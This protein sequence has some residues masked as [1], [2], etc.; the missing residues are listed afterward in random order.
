MQ[1]R[2]PI[3]P[4]SSVQSI[5]PFPLLTPPFAD[6]TLF[7]TGFPADS[8]PVV[9]QTGYQNDIRM[10][11]L[12]IEALLG[13]NIYVP[14]TDRLKDGKTPFQYPV[15]NYIGGIDGQSQAYVMAL[16]P[17]LVGTLEGTTIFVATFAPN[18]DAYA[19]I[20]SNPNEFTAEVKQ[21][22]VPN[23]VSGPGVIPEAFDFDFVT[24]RT[25]KYTPHT[26]HALVNQPQI[27]NNGLC[28]RNL[29]YFNETF[30][31]PAMRT[32][33]VTLYG[34][35][36]GSVPQQLAGRYVKQE[37]YSAS[38]ETVG[39]NAE[40]CASAAAKTDPKALQ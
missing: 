24:A 17:S 4:K 18:N 5:V 3:F 16:I 32:G 19:P 23:P 1:V 7:P 2:D 21:V 26:F 34:P 20:A 39:Y 36:A 37:G 12:Q 15:R 38:A 25:S 13:G 10:A 29:Y 9:V 40:T 30:A 33:N 8:H 31:A 27:L 14:Y 6:K 22:I 35:T 28:Q 11:N